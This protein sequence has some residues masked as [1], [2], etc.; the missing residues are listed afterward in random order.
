MLCKCFT[1]GSYNYMVI[2]YNLFTLIHLYYTK[3]KFLNRSFQVPMLGRVPSELKQQ[4][5]VC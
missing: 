3:V 1:T 4:K 2:S 5:I